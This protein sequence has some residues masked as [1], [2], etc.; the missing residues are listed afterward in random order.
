MPNGYLA[1]SETVER[2][3]ADYIA[4]MTD[5]YA[6]HVADSLWPGITEG[7]LPWRV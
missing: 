5:Y 6:L 4:G 1:H 7:L 3:V 2:G